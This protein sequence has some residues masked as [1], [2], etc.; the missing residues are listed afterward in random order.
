[1]T[2]ADQL[3]VGLIEVVLHFSGLLLDPVKLSLHR[4]PVGSGSV[5]NIRRVLLLRFLVLSRGCLVCRC[6][7]RR[8]CRRRSR[9]RWRLY[10][11]YKVD[12]VA[13]RSESY[14]QKSTNKDYL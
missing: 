2:D 8:G 7:R 4:F 6:L 12:A 9:C 1:L 3:F 14:E 11:I 10:R 5:S 13:T